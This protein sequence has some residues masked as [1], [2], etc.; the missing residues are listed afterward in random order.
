MSFQELPPEII[1][2]VIRFLTDNHSLSVFR[3]LRVDK[4][5]F[6]LALPIAKS[7]VFHTVRLDLCVNRRVGRQVARLCAQF[8]K[9]NAFTCV[10]RLIIEG[11][12]SFGR[13]SR[14]SYE[15]SPP[16]VSHFSSFS[17]DPQDS[18]ESEEQNL[19]R[20]GWN[21]LHLQS[22]ELRSIYAPTTDEHEYRLVTSPSLNTIS[23]YYETNTP[24]GIRQKQAFLRILSLAPNLKAIYLNVKQN[25]S[26]VPAAGTYSR[27]SKFTQEQGEGPFHLAAIECLRVR[28]AYDPMPAATLEELAAYIDFSVLQTLD[29]T[30]PIQGEAL[31]AWADHLHFLA[32][33]TL[34][35]LLG[36]QM[37]R[38]GQAPDFYLKATRFLQSLPALSD[39]YL[40]EW[41]SQLP[42]GT[43]TQSHGPR[44]RKLSVAGLPW[45]CFT[46]NDI[47]QLGR[48]CPLLEKMSI[49]IR[50]TQGDA[51]EVALYKALGTV[52]NLKFLDLVLDVSDPTLDQE[53][54]SIDP[55]WDDF[56]NQPANVNLGGINPSRN[57]HI[58]RLLINTLIDKQ[59]A[60][61]ILEV[62]SA[63]KPQ[64]APLLE[65]L[66][67]SIQG[68]TRPAYFARCEFSHLVRLLSTEWTIERDIRHEHRN[69][70]DARITMIPISRSFKMENQVKLGI[71]TFGEVFLWL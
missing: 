63:A 36:T 58:R 35:L 28:H 67:L 23:P 40:D 34:R 13:G 61:S 44:L 57:G 56:D 45:Q 7:L 52:R 53:H 22:F 25:T 24:E 50:R 20:K 21:Q 51:R 42:I 17:R 12:F 26:D 18:D 14:D 37:G 49:P 32:L 33:Q 29:L 46:E 16:S 3:L 5:C 70:V 41:H 19:V 8:Q 62:I 54:A 30:S 6:A 71:V 39:V 2:L 15:W 59:L 38:T 66:S 31:E 11:H 65:R 60:C 27:W 4:R 55:D 43:L 47:L 10:R 69:K 68:Q 48:H 1:S 9:A 64:D